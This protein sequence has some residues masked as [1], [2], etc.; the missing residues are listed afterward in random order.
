[1]SATS[2]QQNICR[3]FV[4]CKRDVV[5]VLD[6]SNFVTHD[7]FQDNL[8]FISSLMERLYSMDGQFAVVSFSD[9]SDIHINFGIQNTNKEQLLDMVSF[10]VAVS[11]Q[12]CQHHLTAFSQF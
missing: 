4:G 12:I 11:L 7:Q 10:Y 9:Y 5:F 1:M 3:A 2:V 8:M 6:S